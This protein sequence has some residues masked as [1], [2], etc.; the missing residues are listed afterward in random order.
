MNS[1]SEVKG[2]TDLKFG[3]TQEEIDMLK[4]FMEPGDEAQFNFLP[5]AHNKDKTFISRKQCVLSA[6]ESQINEIRKKDPF[7]KVGFILFNNEVV[8]VGDGKT[9]NVHIVGDKL[10][11]VDNIVNALSTFKL[12]TPLG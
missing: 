6:I 7:K 12:T 2:K 11:N 8:I 4:Q 9:E 1:T 3:L 10:N 5:G